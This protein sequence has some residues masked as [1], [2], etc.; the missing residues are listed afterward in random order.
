MLSFYTAVLSRK[1][2]LLKNPVDWRL[3]SILPVCMPVS[4]GLYWSHTMYV[5][6]VQYIL[7]VHF[8]WLMWC[9]G[10]FV[11]IATVA[12]VKSRDMHW[13][14]LAQKD[15]KDISLSSLR[16]LLVADGANPCTNKINI[17][18]IKNTHFVI[19]Y[20]YTLSDTLWIISAMI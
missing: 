14:L 17:I 13:G 10:C 20:I 12:V 4:T 11:V 6:T 18:Y 9:A 7:E 5:K 3:I 8:H 2:R 1:N 15:H 19:N 16:M